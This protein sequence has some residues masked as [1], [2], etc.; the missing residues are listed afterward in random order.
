MQEDLEK[1][2]A[3]AIHLTAEHRRI[4]QCLRHVEQQLQLFSADSPGTLA[5]VIQDLTQLRTELSKHFDEEESGGCLEEAVIH[6]PASSA[7]ASRV[8]HE[9]PQ[10]LADLDSLIEKFTSSG[11]ADRAL[12]EIRSEFEQFAK[13]LRAHEAA[14]TRIFQT[15][16]GTE[17]P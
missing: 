10:M 8:V 9:H 17:A 14:E 1:Y 3:L 7:E 16:F 4:A 13:R 6:H 5:G 12:G 15:C 2:R 11:G